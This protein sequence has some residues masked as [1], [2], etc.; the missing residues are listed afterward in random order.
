MKPLLKMYAYTTGKRC[1]SL[2]GSF[3]CDEGICIIARTEAF[4][5]E[6]GK[7]AEGD[8]VICKHAEP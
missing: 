3:C 7:E 6:N 4:L 5:D 8:N 1:I 2:E